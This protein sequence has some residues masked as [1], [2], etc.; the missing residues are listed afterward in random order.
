MWLR[1]PFRASFHG[2]YYVEAS[3]QI[4]TRAKWNPILGW[5]PLEIKHSHF[6]LIAVGDLSLFRH[7][8]SG[9]TCAFDYSVN[10]T[11][12]RGDWEDGLLFLNERK[13]P[14]VNPHIR[15]GGCCAI[16]LWCVENIYY[17]LANSAFHSEFEKLLAFGISIWVTI[18]SGIHRPAN[19]SGIHRPADVSGIHRPA[20]L[21]A[22]CVPTM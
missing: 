15:Q 9:S 6:E 1:F 19:V 22:F 4:A 8:Y 2:I 10:C 5:Q 18:V 11:S 13:L 12:C 14:C 3:A 17:P 20:N 16:K 21:H 7:V